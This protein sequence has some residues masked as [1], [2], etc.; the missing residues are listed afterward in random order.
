MSFSQMAEILK[1][2]HKEEILVSDQ[3]KDV[4]KPPRTECMMNT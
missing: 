1:Q 4:L 2:K 3:Q